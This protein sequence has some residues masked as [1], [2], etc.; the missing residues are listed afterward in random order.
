LEKTRA[1]WIFVRGE[2]DLA[3]PIAHMKH[4]LKLSCLVCC[5]AWPA[6]AQQSPQPDIAPR[7]REV[8]ASA[9]KYLAETPFF[10]ITA[11][12]WQEHVRDS[13][14]KVQFTRVI[15]MEVKRPDRLHAVI[16]SPRVDQQFWY[17]G[18]SLT[19]FDGKRNLYSSTSMPADLDKML[20]T[21][22]D[23]FGIDLPLI[24]LAISDPYNNAMARVE[25]GTYLGVS[26][27]MGFPCHHLAFT[28]ENVDWQMWIQDGP[29]PLIRKFVITHKNEPGA[30][31]FTALVRNW[32]LNDRIAD[33]DFAFSP[34]P[35]ATKIEMRKDTVTP[36]DNSTSGS[37][38]SPT[39]R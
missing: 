7:A 15:D 20:D 37:T 27:A 22:H 10:G 24:D 17:D 19:I 18:K 28:Q 32:N 25:T 34:P 21:A 39:G 12:I 30:P 14:Q 31:E 6:L 2:D 16:Q 36:P 38:P 3:V 35:G 4:L 8:L 33:S 1:T 11:E 13:G 26:R 23:Q 5:A 29:Q 9:T